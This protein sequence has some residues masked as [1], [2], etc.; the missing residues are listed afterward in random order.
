MLKRVWH[1]TRLAQQLVEIDG[2]DLDLQVDAVE[3]RSRN[4]AH[5]VGALVLVADA[6][7]LGVPVVATWTRIHRGHQHERGGIFGRVFRPT[8]TYNPVL[9]RLTHH[10]QNGAIEFWEFIQ[11]EELAPFSYLHQQSQCR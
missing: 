10:L 1:C 4:L 5:I 6:F 2:L 11:A 8:D 7:L 3:Q 9:Q